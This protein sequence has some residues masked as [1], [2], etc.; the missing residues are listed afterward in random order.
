M[1][2][3]FYSFDTPE[4]IGQLASTPQMQRLDDIGMHC[5]CEYASAPLY[6]Q[7]V[8]PYSRLIH[9]IGVARIVWKHT[10]DIK[11]A[12]AGLLHDIATPVF[13]HAIDFMNNDHMSQE[14]TEAKT[15]QFIE[16]SNPIIALLEKYGIKAQDV[17]DY[18]IYPIADNDT[19]ML[20]ADRLEYTLGNAHSLYKTTPEQL[21]AVYS[22]LTVTDNERS[23]PELCFRSADTAKLFAQLALRNSYLYVSD[24]DRFLMQYLADIV[25]RAIEAEVLSTDDL[26][27]TESNVISKMTQNREIMIEWKKYESIS[28]VSVSRTKPQDRYC[29]NISAKK[30]Y[31]DPLVMTDTAP[32]RI[33]ASDSVI[34]R[35][36]T[37]FLDKDFDYWIYSE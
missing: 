8:S 21:E 15:L 14:S 10:G 7:A 4:L 23:M 27:T 22:D 25:R 31:I 19:P 2:F 34:G 17:G 36:I 26:Y 3:A 1:N 13:A 28:A 11:Q 24:K 35:N 29:V 18:H 16:N 6:R 9:S 30:R 32:V 20:S 33:S 12:V 5:G 37:A